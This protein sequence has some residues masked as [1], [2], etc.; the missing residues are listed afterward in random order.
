[1]P[2]RTPTRDQAPTG[3]ADTPRQDSQRPRHGD[4][5]DAGG[6][7]STNRRAA[8]TQIEDMAPPEGAPPPP[9]ELHRDPPLPR[10]GRQAQRPGQHGRE[11]PRPGVRDVETFRSSSEEGFGSEAEGAERRTD[12]IRGGESAKRRTSRP[13]TSARRDRGVGAEEPPSRPRRR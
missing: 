5:A 2:T 11:E 10:T 6:Q 4:H 3:F 9:G 12:A 8:T 7:E 13:S 1:M